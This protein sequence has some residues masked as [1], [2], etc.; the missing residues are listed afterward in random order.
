M[1]RV[2]LVL[3][4]AAFAVA[5]S[6]LGATAQ[7][8]LIGTAQDHSLVEGEDCARFHTQTYTSFP[9]QVS[10]EEHRDVPLAGVDVLK[11]RAGDEGGV[12]IRGWD[13]SIARLTICKCAVGQTKLLAQRTLGSVSVSLRPGEII[14]TGPEINETQ[15]WW[16]HMILFVP[17]AS[18]LDVE[19]E[20]GG[21]AIRN[22]SGH[23]NARATNGG[24][25]LAQSAGDHK[26]STRN[27]GI[28]LDRITGRVDA[29]TQNGPISLRLRDAAVPSLE[30]RT[31]DDGAIYCNLKGCADR[32]GN[33]TA[34]R[35]VLR[36]G[37]AAPMIRL[38]TSRAPIMIEQVR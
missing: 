25:S 18:N 33:W 7:R 20:N 1:R 36:I 16:V 28:S 35:R 6:A 14:A 24:I 2:A 31:D 8:Q 23:V 10:A 26:I 38:S 3:T 17:K 15:V 12:S 21:I 5:G 13:R 37:T 34:N 27:G 19:A 9:A 4:L 32:L 30:A 29:T 22:M 11:V